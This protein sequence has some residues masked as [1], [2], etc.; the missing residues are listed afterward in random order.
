MPFSSL[1]GFKTD[2]SQMLLGAR[3]LMI[4]LGTAVRQF[5]FFLLEKGRKLEKLNKG[6]MLVQ[7]KVSELE[8]MPQRWLQLGRTVIEIA[9]FC[10]ASKW[11]FCC[12]WFLNHFL[13]IASLVKPDVLGSFVICL[14]GPVKDWVLFKITFFDNNQLLNNLNKMSRYSSS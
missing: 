3:R 11:L 13:L 9:V 10:F 4:G 1:C 5:I 6:P 7:P 8:L 12:C 2:R 14:V